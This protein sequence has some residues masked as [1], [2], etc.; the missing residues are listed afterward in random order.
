MQS[1]SWNQED[2]Q[3]YRAERSLASRRDSEAA[4]DHQK[5]CDETEELRPFGEENARG[6]HR[7]GPTADIA[8]AADQETPTQN[9]PK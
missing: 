7:I 1:E 6:I 4:H 3:H 8:Q 9:G 5:R 2:N